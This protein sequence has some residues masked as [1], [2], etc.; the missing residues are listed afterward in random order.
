MDMESLAVELFWKNFLLLLSVPSIPPQGF[1][2]LVSTLL[3][4]SS[5]GNYLN[6][7]A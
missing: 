7:A 5:K 3:S 6:S 1:C 4:V 2:Q